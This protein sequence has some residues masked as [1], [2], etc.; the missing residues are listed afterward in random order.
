LAKSIYSG[1]V[2][3]LGAL[4]MI[5]SVAFSIPMSYFPNYAIG[6]GATVASIGIF[7]SS[8]ALASAIMSPR[9]G[10]LSDR[11]GRKKIIVFGLLGDIVIGALTGLAPN[12]IW[13]LIIRVLNGAVASAAMLAAEALLIDSVSPA[14]WGEANGFVLSMGMIGRN[15]G[16]LFGGA[17]QSLAVTSGFSL[18]DSYRVPYFVD[19]GMAAIALLL[20]V[21]KVPA[22]SPSGTTPLRRLQEAVVLR[23]R[24][25]LSMSFKILLICSFINGMGLGFLIPIMALFYN[26]KFGIEP[27]EIGL[28][29]SIGGFIGLLA[30]YLA[31]RLSDVKGRK[32]L[33][34]IGSSLSAVSVF[35]L[36]LT[37][38][39]THAAAVLSLRSL[40]FN[41][42]MPAMRAL[43]ADITPPEARGRYFG[44]FVTAFTAGDVISPLISAYLY[45]VYRF[46]TFQL[47]GITVGGFSIPFF[48]NAIL[49][50]TAM[51]LLLT[52]IKE[53]TPPVAPD[54]RDMEGAS[55][56]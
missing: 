22:T 49:T 30:S 32:P 26:D 9:T 7:S 6:L 33:I 48:I 23:E 8:F 47:A 24:R 12:W 37:G 25:P 39:V 17:V 40:G 16:P 5:E 38:D 31:G 2:L 28:I 54:D 36:P 11:V 13:L 15:I 50:A 51:T 53:P 44:L 14:R 10:G 4:Q 52:L 46:S 43:R 42:N 29:L 19:A 18:V 34:A 35:M 1:T 27:V 41:I 21:W 55:A 45:D 3:I 20:V 56:A